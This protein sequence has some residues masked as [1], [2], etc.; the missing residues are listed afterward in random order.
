MIRYREYWPAFVDLAREPDVG[1]VE[2]IDELLEVPFIKERMVRGDVEAKFALSLHE[3]HGHLMRD[4]G[5]DK[6]W[7]VAT[8]FYDTMP[9]P[10][11]KLP[12][13]EPPPKEPE[14]PLVEKEYGPPIPL[15]D[16]FASGAVKKTVR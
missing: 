9:A 16:L 6:W 12:L 5:D 7:V 8:F 10:T 13:W 14:V 3:T 1:E 4:F 11:E 2:T 15:D